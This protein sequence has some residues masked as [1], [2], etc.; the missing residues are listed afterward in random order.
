MGDCLAQAPVR[1]LESYRGAELGY[2]REFIGALRLPGVE[3]QRVDLELEM[4]VEGEGCAGLKVFVGEG[5]E[6]RIAWES[7]AGWLVLDRSAGRPSYQEQL[8]GWS[9]LPSVQG[10]SRS[11]SWRPCA[12]AS[13]WTA[14][15]SKSSR[16][17]ALQSCPR[18]SIRRPRA[19]GSS[20]SAKAAV[21]GSCAGPGPWS[22]G[23]RVAK[24]KRSKVPTVDQE[25]ADSYHEPIW[26]RIGETATRDRDPTRAPSSGSPR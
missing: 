16:M 2:E 19:A 1:E 24:T 9:G 7:G 4:R 10:S 25:S 20:F 18:P 6:T 3:G 5:E 13:S 23:E 17:T 15:R 8:P 12:C 21:R 11:R 22:K 14:L 26:P